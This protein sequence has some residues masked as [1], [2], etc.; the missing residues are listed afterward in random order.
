MFSEKVALVLSLS[1]KPFTTKFGMGCCVST[2]TKTPR[3][4]KII[5]KIK[6]LGLLGRVSF[7]IHYWTSTSRLSNG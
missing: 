2:L 5:N 1:Q 3:I 7:K 4:K 6:S